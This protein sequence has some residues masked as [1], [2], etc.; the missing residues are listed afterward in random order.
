MSEGVV[1]VQ[2]NSNLCDKE[3]SDDRVADSWNSS[4]CGMAFVFVRFYTLRYSTQVICNLICLSC[5][6]ANFLSVCTIQAEVK[7]QIAKSLTLLTA[8]D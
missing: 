3:L 5:S 2:C 8:D 7:I 1:G 4:V 6:V